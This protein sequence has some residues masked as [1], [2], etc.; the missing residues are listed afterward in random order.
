MIRPCLRSA[1]HQ[2]GSKTSKCKSK[3][4][5]EEDERGEGGLQG[6]EDREVT[7]EDVA[8]AGGGG[9]EGGGGVGAG[10]PAECAVETA[11]NCQ[12]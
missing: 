6:V 11:G 7:R 2:P 12:T 3:G 10:H 5:D 4:E 8:E 9:G 1:T